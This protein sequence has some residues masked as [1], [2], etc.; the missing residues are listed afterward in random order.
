M[1]PQPWLAVLANTPS[2]FSVRCWAYPQALGILLAGAVVW[3]IPILA[4]AGET[5][6]DVNDVSFLWPVPTNLADLRRTIS[7]DEQIPGRNETIWPID[8]FQAVIAQAQQ[9]SIKNSAGRRNQIVFRPFD[10]EFSK[11]STW[12]VVSFRVDPSGIGTSPEFIRE[13]G[14]I[15]QIRLVLQPVTL[16][17]NGAIRIHDVTVHLVFSFVKPLELQSGRGQVFAPDRDAFRAIVTGLAGLK[18]AAEKNG[19]TTTGK[20]GVHPGLQRDVDGFSEE[21]RTFLLSHLGRERLSAIAF[22]GIDPPEPWIF[23]AMSKRGTD[24]KLQSFPV[25]DGNT[26]QMLILAGGVPVVPTPVTTNLDAGRG[27]HTSL[28]FSRTIRGQLNSPVFE[29][30]PDLKHRDIPDFIANPVHSHFFNTDCVSCHTESSRRIVLGLGAINSDF[31]YRRP[32]RISSVDE[33]LLP[34]DQWNLR[35]F[36][37]FPTGSAG[38]VATVTMRT[39]NEAAESAHFINHHYISNDSSATRQ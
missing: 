29:D 8:E 23:F 25:L 17:A 36:G 2:V 10:E 16:G 31:Q 22:M 9:I 18:A 19:I 33:T 6:F 3:M 13:F 37:W 7:A 28:L 15:P 21:V 20:L 14:E 5:R 35:N 27:V 32:D 12:K 4:E 30:V 34:K 38:G 39:A 11:Q 24:L 1:K 26:S